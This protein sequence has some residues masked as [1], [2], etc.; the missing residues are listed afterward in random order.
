[1]K[2]VRE[3]LQ[4]IITRG[5]ARQT[6]SYDPADSRLHGRSIFLVGAPRSG[7][8]WVH[9]LLATHPDVAT[10]G[11]L[12]VFC[13]GLTGLFANFEN[14]D[15]WMYLH[16]WVTRDELLRLSREFVD[17][18]MQSAL[19]RRPGATRVLDKTP[20]HDDPFAA[21][22][23]EVFPDAAFVHLIRN[24]RD[25]VSS[26]RDLWGSWSPTARSWSASAA[27]WQRLVRDLRA[28][29]SHRRYL[30]VRYEDLVAAP[31]AGLTGI[32]EFLGLDH[33]D[34]FV[35]DAVAFGR[36]PIN[37]RPSDPRVGV[38]KWAGIDPLAERDIVRA[39]G[40]LMVELGYLTPTQRAEIAGRRSWR[41]LPRGAATGAA[42]V[43]RR[44][45]RERQALTHRGPGRPA[46]LR[47]LAD[48]L[49][50]AGAAGA[51]A[52][53]PL[54]APDVA[55]LGGDE[56]GPDA[57]ARLLTSLLA[58]ARP[59]SVHTDQHSAAVQLLLA[60]GRRQHHQYT[61]R[62]RLLAGVVIDGE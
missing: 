6:A 20:T 55:H 28:Q 51:E 23:A 15:P 57:V 14:P 62:D 18:V 61:F 27:R 54:L 44:V 17:G 46:E 35:R 40:D 24:A 56:R 52:L 58:G 53:R 16:T 21:L 10:S 29:L 37:V 22:L 8:T 25:S 60:D 49:L 33:D 4:E 41:D 43:R 45:A 9:Q 7:T 12:H 30:E 1:M 34:E 2:P 31:E 39:A 3:T 13:E 48:E 11:E 32:L 59:V 36:A 5:S 38:D 47:G 50:R 26:Q 42:R 19:A